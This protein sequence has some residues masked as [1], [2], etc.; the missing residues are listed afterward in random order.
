VGS[1]SAVQQTPT[2]TPPAETPEERAERQ[3]IEEER[4]NLEKEIQSLEQTVR[5]AE[6]RVDEISDDATRAV[7]EYRTIRSITQGCLESI[8][9]LYFYLI[10]A[11]PTTFDPDRLQPLSER[12]SGFERSLAEARKAEQEAADALRRARGRLENLRQYGAQS[13]ASLTGTDLEF[14][15]KLRDEEAQRYQERQR[16]LEEQEKQKELE[17]APQP[18]SRASDGT[19]PRSAESF[20]LADACQAPVQVLTASPTVLGRGDF[21]AFFGIDAG[22]DAGGADNLFIRSDGGQFVDLFNGRP[23]N[24]RTVENTAA[25]QAD[26]V[27]RETIRTVAIA[28]ASGVTFGAVDLAGTG[29]IG[30]GTQELAFTNPAGADTATRGDVTSVRGGAGIRVRILRGPQQGRVFYVK[31]HVRGGR[32]RMR[33]GR[34]IPVL[35]V[36]GGSVSSQ[37][38]TV[39]STRFAAGAAAGMEFDSVDWWAGGEFSRDRFDRESTIGLDFSQSVPGV[40]QQA[41]TRTSL[42]KDGARFVAGAT[43]FPTSRFG[44]SGDTAVGRDTW[45]AGARLVV[46]VAGGR[47]RR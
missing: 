21:N 31:S 1:A 45:V 36:N 46:R 42:E 16:Q 25:A 35:I 6:A 12:A 37:V 7:E 38:H 15:R 44:I 23:V 17:K 26:L 27:Y 2:Q 9:W 33:G 39:D 43:W 11:V 5:D 10:R 29:S 14:D 41:L 19:L 13:A 40:S 8:D 34:R 30:T 22:G 20:A 18:I 4:R 47:V 32:D 28:F 3:R 24:E